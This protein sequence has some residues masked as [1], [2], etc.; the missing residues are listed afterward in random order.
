MNE[1]YAVS[2][3]KVARRR[4]LKIPED[5]QVIGFTDGV[6]SKHATPSLTTVSQH[7]QGMG[8]KAANLLINKLEN[9]EEES[10]HHTTIIETELIERESTN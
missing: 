10:L 9:T 8:Q 1:L 6:L 7:A 3:M 4:G 5:I 2:L